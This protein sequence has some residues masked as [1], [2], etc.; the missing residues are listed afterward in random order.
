MDYNKVGGMSVE[1][2][3]KVSVETLL[4]QGQ[5]VQLP[6]TGWSMYPL[7]AEGRDQVIIEPASPAELRRGDVVLYRRDSGIL[8]L[9]R[10][11]RCTE[12]GFYMVGDN[13]RAIEGPLRPDQIK[14]K[15]AAVI[16]KGKT[17]PVTSPVYRILT[18]LWLL[19]RPVR[20]QI[21]RFAASVKRLFRR[22]NKME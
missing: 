14:G 19:A 17:I 4:A 18:G 16:R 8:V 6:P 9:H 3:C 12:A 2:N 7:I 5:S 13:Q 15:M 20:P 11:C 10:I 22:S 1:S 21:S